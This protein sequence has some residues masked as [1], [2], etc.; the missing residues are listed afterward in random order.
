MFGVDLTFK[1]YE[2]DMVSVGFIFIFCLES[3]LGKYTWVR[4]T[5]TTVMIIFSKVPWK[6]LDHYYV[7]SRFSKIARH[8]DK[9]TPTVEDLTDMDQDMS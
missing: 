1:W 6:L 5:F 8:V 3:T 7:Q 4:V 2:D 9:G